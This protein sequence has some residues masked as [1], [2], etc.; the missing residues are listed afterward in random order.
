MTLSKK[1]YLFIILFLTPEIFADSKSFIPDAPIINFKL[2]MFNQEGYQSWYIQG[3]EGTYIN[4]KQIDIKGM[5]LMIFSSDK[6][7]CLQTTIESPKASIMLQDNKAKSNNEIQATGE[8]Y[9]LYGKDW[10]WNGELKKININKNVKV[11]FDKPLTEVFTHE[12]K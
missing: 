6:D 4:E 2:P 8:G 12:K 5:Q 9:R 1:I 10:L 11:I 3:D 7:E